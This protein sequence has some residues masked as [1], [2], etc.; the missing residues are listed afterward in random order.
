MPL[1][2]IALSVV[3]AVVL[4]G[5]VYASCVA[6]G[7]LVL[8]T[9]G[10]GCGCGCVGRAG[11]CSNSG[12]CSLRCCRAQEKAFDLFVSKAHGIYSD[13]NDYVEVVANWVDFQT[14][15]VTIL[16]E[17]TQ[18]IADLGVSRRLQLTRRP[19]CARPAYPC[20]P[21]IPL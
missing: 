4:W 15:C 20:V 11:T 5:V 2:L 12:R 1:P 17:V 21:M 10:L 18:K 6:E 7:A 3:V 19:R 13:L 9:R 14:E 8:L 16:V